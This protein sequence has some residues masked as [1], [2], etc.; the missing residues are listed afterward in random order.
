MKLLDRVVII[1]CLIILIVGTG[2]IAYQRGQD[3]VATEHVSIVT[4]IS[5]REYDAMIAHFEEIITQMEADY[6]RLS[7][8]TEANS[9]V[10]DSLLDKLVIARKPPAKVEWSQPFTERDLN[11]AISYTRAAIRIH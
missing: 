9:L 11:R 7:A 2:I 10:V 4:G 6:T 8:L 5:P 3:S 1:A